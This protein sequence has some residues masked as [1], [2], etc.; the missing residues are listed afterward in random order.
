MVNTILFDLDGTLTTSTEIIMDG[1]KHMMD[2][3]FPDVVLT[4]EEQTAFLGRTLVDNFSRY[5]ADPKMLKEM[6]YLYR[7]YTNDMNAKMLK[8]Y[9]NALNVVKYLLDMGVKIGIV[10]SKSYEVA[11]M[12]LKTV[13][14]DKYFDVVVGYEHTNKHKPEPDSLLKAIELL[15]SKPEETVYVGD[16]E[17]DIIAAHKAGMQSVAVTYSYRINQALRQNPTYIVDDL[18]HIKDIII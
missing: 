4:K 2:Q 14:L 7:K 17:N 15:N 10:T 16:H 18:I 11:M 5:T 13:G 6:E 12:D 1:Y 8:T 3:L 9:P